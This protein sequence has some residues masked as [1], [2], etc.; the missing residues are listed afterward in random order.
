MIEEPKLLRINPNTPR[1]SGK[2]INALRKVPTG[3]A[4][5]A[6]LGKGAFSKNINHIDPYGSIAKHAIG[7]ALTV[8][9]GPGDILALLASFKFI[10]SGDIVLSAF[11]AYQGCAAAGD[12]VS[13]MMKN[14][15]A[16]GFI[17]DG[18]MRDLSGLRDVGLPAW[19]TGLTPASPVSKGP[20][21]V[22]LDIEIGGVRVS[23][24]DIIIADIDGI[25]AI[26]LAELDEITKRCHEI[27]ELEAS[28][29]QK[30]RDGLMVPEEIEELLASDKVEYR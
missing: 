21:S 24:G 23:S 27:L 10:K 11:G 15:G 13:G 12:R 19:C 3:V 8:D 6:M 29:D 14:C 17:T 20:G 2:Q 1:P 7:P 30:V 25:V 9:A 26:Q 22:G 28:L 4:N 5:D 16:A 18:P